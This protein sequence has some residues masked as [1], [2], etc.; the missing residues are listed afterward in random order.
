MNEDST[1]VATGIR[2]AVNELIP[3][4]L[5]ESWMIFDIGRHDEQVQCVAGDGPMTELSLG[6]AAVFSDLFVEPFFWTAFEGEHCFTVFAF[7]D[8][9]ADGRLRGEPIAMAFCPNDEQK[10]SRRRWR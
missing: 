2:A 8:P 6:H 5:S 3:R 10:R 1:C 4:V 9:D 7:A